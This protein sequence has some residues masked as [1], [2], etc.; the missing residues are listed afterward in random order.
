MSV[1]PCDVSPETISFIAERLRLAAASPEVAGL[2]PVL[3]FAFGFEELDADGTL[4][5]RFEGG[6]FDIGWYEPEK[7]SR[8]HVCA[9]ELCGAKVF[10]LADTLSMLAGKKLKIETVE[11]GYPIAA[12][13]TKQLLR[14]V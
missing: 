2:V 8:P 1:L 4:T 3:C 14:A 9:V 12:A 7:V 6:D 10:V 13:R 11:V 5:A